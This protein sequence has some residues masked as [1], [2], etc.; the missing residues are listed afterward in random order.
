MVSPSIISSLEAGVGVVEAGLALHSTAVV[1]EAVQA[2]F[3]PARCQL[4]RA[5]ILL[6]LVVV[7]MVALEITSQLQLTAQALFF[8]LSPVPA[9]GAAARQRGTALPASPAAAGL[10]GLAVVVVVAA[11]RSPP[12]PAE[13]ETHQQ[14]LLLKAITAV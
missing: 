1:V 9:V 14:R 12:A 8:Q 13:S 6:Q 2:G 3:A 11:R 10:A 5:V 7:A 4:R